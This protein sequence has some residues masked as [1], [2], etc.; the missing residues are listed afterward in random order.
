LEYDKKIMK[1]FS[2][3]SVYMNHIFVF[4]SNLS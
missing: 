4:I 2:C 3:C 1:D